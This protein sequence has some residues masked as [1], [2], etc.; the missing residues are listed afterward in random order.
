MAILTSA[1]GEN[2][3]ITAAQT[4]ETFDGKLQ[5]QFGWQTEKRDSLLLTQ[6]N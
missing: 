5:L 3:L 4:V 6:T 1:S 2:G